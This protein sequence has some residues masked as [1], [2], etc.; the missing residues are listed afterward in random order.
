M[1]LVVPHLKKIFLIQITSVITAEEL[2]RVKV[3]MN[4]KLQQVRDSH[5]PVYDIFFI[6]I[7]FYHI[8]YFC[9]GK[10]GAE[11]GRRGPYGG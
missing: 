2:K 7:A 6:E 10:K 3:Q 4:Q 9:T 1:F 5:S 8:P 11:A